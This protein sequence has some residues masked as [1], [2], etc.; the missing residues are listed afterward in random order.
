ML[1]EI[2]HSPIGSPATVSPSTLKLSNFEL[3]EQDQLATSTAMAKYLEY[4]AL[5]ASSS[6]QMCDLQNY[7]QWL[8]ME[9]KVEK[10]AYTYLKVINKNADCK[11]TILEAL[12][13]LHKELDDSNTMQYLVVVGDYKTYNHIQT[14][15]QTYTKQ[16]Q[17]VIPFPG[18]F[19][20]LRN[21]QEALMKI[22]W[23]AGVKEIANKSGYRG[24]TLT[25]LG[26][27]SNFSIATNFFFQV[28]EALYSHMYTT[29]IEVNKEDCPISE[30]AFIAYL[31]KKR[32]RMI[33][34]NF[35]Y[36]LYWKTV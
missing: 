10:S 17:W 20:T 27:C 28:W 14:V 34:G 33:I 31:E 22:Y 15:K 25:Q 3:N 35:G 5:S 8:S 9:D 23:D 24:E 21:Y 1:K 32:S 29:Y 26:K 18:D 6:S 4:I 13:T 16:L 11:E 2:E 30:K 19:H 36:A 7:L 12:C